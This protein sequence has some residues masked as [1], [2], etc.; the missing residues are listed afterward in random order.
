MY[1]HSTWVTTV[2][3]MPTLTTTAT[4]LQNQALSQPPSSQAFMAMLCAYRASGGTARSD[5]LSRLLQDQLRRGYVSLEGLLAQDQ[6]FSF[7]WRHTRWIPMF[8]FDLA[9][10]SLRRG[11]QQVVAELSPTFDEWSLA[12]WFAEPNDWLD[13][14]KPVDLIHTELSAVLAAARA[15]RFVAAG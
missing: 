10:L 3:H 8:Q 15:D 2:P 9:D 6:V 11:P 1:T 12:M 13:A 7:V 4:R 5:D 14:R